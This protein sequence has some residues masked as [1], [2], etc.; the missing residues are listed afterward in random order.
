MIVDYYY[1]ALTLDQSVLYK[2][3]SHYWVFVSV[4]N[5]SAEVVCSVAD[6]AGEPVYPPVA[7]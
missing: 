2:L 1:G 4:D 6:D 7:V 5:L 3:P